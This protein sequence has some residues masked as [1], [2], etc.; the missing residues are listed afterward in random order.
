MEF[1]WFC[2]DHEFLTF[3]LFIVKKIIKDL[4]YILKIVNLNGWKKKIENWFYYK[5]FNLRLN[6]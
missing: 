2:K 1:R 4:I 6:F 5:E 3:N